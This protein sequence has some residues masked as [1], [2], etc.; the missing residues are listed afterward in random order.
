MGA[1]GSGGAQAAAWLQRSDGVL[2]AAPGRA[3][4][5][6]GDLERSAG[7]LERA[8]A[9]SAMACEVKTPSP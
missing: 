2:L 5:Q 6:L 4:L 8:F 3:S 1:A 7:N 9:A